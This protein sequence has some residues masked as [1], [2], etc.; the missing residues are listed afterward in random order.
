MIQTLKKKV[1]IHCFGLILFPKG[2]GAKDSVR[3]VMLVGSGGTYGRWSGV[4]GSW[5][6]GGILSKGTSSVT[7]GVLVRELFKKQ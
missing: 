6:T 4:K 7:P 2:S 5:V 3:R 1:L